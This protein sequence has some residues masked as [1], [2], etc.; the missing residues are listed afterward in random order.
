MTWLLKYM[1]AA[2]TGN[3]FEE[4]PKLAEI[5]PMDKLPHLMIIYGLGFV[6]IW[7][8]LYLMYRHVLKKRGMLQL[9]EIE[10]YETRFSANEKLS[11]VL[12]GLLSVLLS[13]LSIGLKFPIGAAL[14]GWVYNLIWILTIIRVR[15]RKKQLKLLLET[16]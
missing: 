1:Y 2:I 3:L 11:L 15:K 14:A 8:C 4:M 5:I 9:N 10:L 7:L 6:C 13:L 16:H 12:I